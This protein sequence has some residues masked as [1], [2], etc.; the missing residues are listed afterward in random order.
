M[1]LILSQ[2][3]TFLINKPTILYLHK[4]KKKPDKRFPPEMTS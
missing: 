2:V 4:K 1:I 3:K